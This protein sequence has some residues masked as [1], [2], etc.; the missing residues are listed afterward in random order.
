MI[1]VD[2]RLSLL[3]LAGRY[4]L[5]DRV[6][7]TWTFHYRLLRALAEPNRFGALSRD[8]NDDVRRFAAEPPGDRL[9]VLDPREVTA[10]VAELSVAHGLNR[11]AA[12]LM[13]SGLRY[14]AAIHLSAGNVG[15]DWP[16]SMVALGLDLTV[17][18]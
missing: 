2:D 18:S 3:A 5:G 8:A 14:G 1:I 12:E 7:T 11:L 16:E 9:V 13:A 17:V 15:R 10:R 6:A 4:H